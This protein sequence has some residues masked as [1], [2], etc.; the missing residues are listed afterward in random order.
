MDIAYSLDVVEN[1]LKDAE[2]LIKALSEEN[3]KLREALQK[4]CGFPENPVLCQNDC[5]NYEICKGNK[6]EIH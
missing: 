6:Y 5:E 3:I 4:E 1:A 2:K